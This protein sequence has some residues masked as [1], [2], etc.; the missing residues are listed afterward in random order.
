MQSEETK[1]EPHVLRCHGWSIA[2]LS[3]EL[4]PVATDRT[5]EREH[6]SAAA[7]LAD[8][9]AALAVHL[10][11]PPRLR[12]KLRSTTCWSSRSGRRDGGP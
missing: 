11:Y 1:M 5:L 9:L 2:A 6:P 10:A 3:R 8:D 12:M 7:C 4:G